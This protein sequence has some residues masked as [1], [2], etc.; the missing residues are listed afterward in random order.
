MHNGERG[1]GIK[2]IAKALKVS[3]GTVDRALHGRPGVSEKTKARVL[4][5]AHQM[6]Y[7]PNLAAQVL[8]LNRRLCIGVVLPTHISH[9]FDPIRAGIRSAASAVV[10]IQV[11]LHFH[12]YPRLGVGD[13]AALQSTLQRRYD[14]IIFLPGNAR[15]FD[16]VIRKLSRNGAA[17]I[18]VGSD[19]P[20]SERVGAVSA[21]AFIS[22]AIA[23]ELLSH[24]LVRKANVAV[25]SGELFT[26]DHAE[27]LRG[28]A[29]TLAVQAPHLT[30]LPALESHERPKQ[31]YL[32]TKRLMLGK[33]RP[34]GL[35]LSTANS[36][37]VLQALDEMKLLEKVQIVTTDLFQE[38]VPFIELGKVLATLY[39]RPFTQGKIAFE[40]LLAHLVKGPAS[41]PTVQLAPHVV[42]RSNLALFADKVVATDEESS[43]V[44]KR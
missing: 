27:K 32:Q 5:M 19:A 26:L 33:N 24:K 44:A 31:A 11:E 28:F 6:G 15:N 29:A 12:D 42:F 41:D 30:L 37:P 22:G 4:Q 1:F 38:L 3:I 35:Y 14:G 21:H 10:G 43:W 17:M 18:C 8:K 25:F 40:N 13:L 23:A 16:P 39:Q 9:F 36:I 2:S 20:G 7:K 34:E